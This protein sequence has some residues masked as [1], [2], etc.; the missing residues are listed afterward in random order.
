MAPPQV[1]LVAVA[2]AREIELDLLLRLVDG[3]L[4]LLG[5]LDLVGIAGLVEL[6]QRLQHALDDLGHAQQLAGGQVEEHQHARFDADPDLPAWG[7]AEMGQAILGE[8]EKLYITGSLLTVD[9][10][11]LGRDRLII[12][13]T[14][15]IG[16]FDGL[17]VKLDS[18]SDIVHIF[19]D[20]GESYIGERKQGLICG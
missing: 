8:M 16:E 10:P 18:I 1:V 20:P 11:L 17:I 14:G 12:S 7:T 19:I 3:L 2:D 15:H 6:H 13:P 4:E 9:Q 5:L